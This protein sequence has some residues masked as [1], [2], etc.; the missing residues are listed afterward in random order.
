MFLWR[1]GSGGSAGVRG[2]R[3]AALTA[4]AAGVALVLVGSA[5]AA[6]AYGVAPSKG[7]VSPI[8]VG[9]AYTCTAEIDNNNSVSQ[10]TVR[11]TSLDDE[12]DSS[13]GAHTTTMAIN[14]ST[15]GLTLLDLG[16]G[17]PTCDATGCT[18]PYNT[19][20]EVTF[21]HYTVVA[22]DFPNVSDTATY[23]WNDTC[24]SVAPA[25]LCSTGP[26]SNQAGASADINPE[27]PAITSADQTTFTVGSAGSF[28]VTT[29]P[30][31]PA[32]TTLSETGAL[33]AGVSFIDD[34]DGTATLAGTPAPGT[35][36]TYALQLTASNGVAPNATQSFIL[37]VTAPPAIT[38]ANSTIFSVGSAGTFTVTTTGF[39]AAT[40][41]ESGSLPSGVTLTDNGDGTGTLAGTPAAGTGGNY[42]VTIRAANG[43]S[44]GATQS[45]D[46]EVAELPS[47]TS[48][49]H[50]SFSV[51]SAGTFT[52]TSTR[53]FPPQVTL[54]EIG[55]LPTGVTF[56][57][58]GDGTAT[59]AGTPAAGT[60]GTYPLTFQATGIA[61]GHTDQSF[62][63]TVIE[64][65]DLALTGVP[66]NITTG[67]TS[68]SG[69]KVTYIAPTVVDEGG[70]TPSVN[71]DHAPGST[72]PIGTT[73]VTCTATD[74]DDTNSPVTAT[75][76]VTVLG[77]GAQ[78]QALLSYV[79]GLPPGTSLPSKV[80]TAINYFNAGD[81]RDT[82]TALTGVI[83]QAKAQSGKK[84][85]KTQANTVIADAKQIR[86][87][88][89]C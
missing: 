78:L 13:T 14:A 84:I 74:S 37:E 5:A 53:G 55:A 26:K 76:T 48:A 56:T 34:G 10:D 44:P 57:D 72:F 50:A 71:C 8:S 24:Q 1:R 9:A 11:V 25:T 23:H 16:G 27:S 46:L 62:T 4:L 33:P 41:S 47:I 29:A 35:G 17:L 49:D 32:T 59:L 58:N 88:L 66:T 12:V 75:F 15:P 70:E 30:G 77:A 81:I 38:S 28:T 45:F 60:G 21:S 82:C 64:D 52:V 85:T 22:S 65:N 54:T 39:P 68:P 20:L 86:A 42:F 36:G 73:T 67:A 89:G 6:Q 19:G 63:L 83:N 80:Q 3:L 40:I 87:V 61:G 51:G 31:V 2:R 18:L 79:N 43:V 69:T 7:C